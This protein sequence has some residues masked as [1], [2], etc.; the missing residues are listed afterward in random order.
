ML[1]G[2]YDPYSSNMDA[3]YTYVQ[4]NLAHWEH[5][6]RKDNER[7]IFKYLSMDT[8]DDNCLIFDQVFNEYEKPAFLDDIVIKG[9]L[10][11]HQ[12]YFSKHDDEFKTL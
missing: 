10:N 1:Y 2:P 7:A 12:S 11:K 5:E 8:T 9:G 4:D 6:L 3:S